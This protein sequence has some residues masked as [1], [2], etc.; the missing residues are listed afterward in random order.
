MGIPGPE[1]TDGVRSLI[2]DIQPGGFILFARNLADPEQTFRLNCELHE[3]CD[4]PPI[5]TLDQEGGRV[6]R[7]KAF[8]GLP[9]SGMELARAGKVDFAT[10]HGELTGKLLG[11]LGFNVNLAPVIDYSLSEGRDNSLGGRCL[12][13]SPEQV[14]ELAGAFLNS[15]EAQGVRGT[16]KHFPGYTFCENDPHAD[17]PRI[18]RSLEE[19]ED[20][21]LGVFR[22]FLKTASSVMIGH[23]HFT[24]WHKESYPASLSPEI[25][26][27]LL[28]RD[29][30]YDGL[31]MSD[32]LEMGAIIWR[33]GAAKA[34]RLAIEAGNDALLI[35]HNPA[36]ALLAREALEEAEPQAMASAVR[37]MK[38]F[39]EGLISP[40]A[41]WDSGTFTEV[42]RETENLRRE[43]LASTGNPDRPLG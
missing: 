37:R 23:G 15:M 7:L 43:V 17:L 9:V 26:N 13:F 6:A 2:R 39:K 5:L 12:G 25:I 28:R 19:M 33:Y 24:H 36:C 22:H 40:P 8:A 35:C 32:D 14:I 29:L 42:V 34:S 1:L 30:G 20:A 3:L 10:R 31:A 16:V 27:G 18:S 11:L 4:T 41:Q 21:E 38:T